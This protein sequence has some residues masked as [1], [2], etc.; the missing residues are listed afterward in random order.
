MPA[1]FLKHWA[2]AFVAIAAAVGTVGLVADPFGVYGTRLVPRLARCKPSLRDYARLAKAYGVAA[3]RPAT[4]L[5]GTSRVARGLDP[6]DP[7]LQRRLGRTYNLGLPGGT[8]D[9]MAALARH[10]AATSPELRTLV[11]GLEPGVFFHDPRPPHASWRTGSTPHP[12]F[13]L[14][15]ARDTLFS[16]DS[17]RATAALLNDDF[18]CE[19]PYLGDGFYQDNLD[20]KMAPRGVRWGAQRIVR[21]GCRHYLPLSRGTPPAAAQAAAQAE[22]FRELLRWSRERGLRVRLFITPLHVRYLEMLRAIGF[23]PIVEDWKR[24]TTRAVAEAAREGADVELW[25][26][27][28]YHPL[29]TEPIP[30]LGDRET[31]MRWYWEP[32]HFR[33]VLGRQIVARMIAG[34]DGTEA[35]A[36][37]GRRLTPENVEAHLAAAWEAGERHRAA[38][39]AQVDEA[40]AAA[41]R[42]AAE[43]AR[44]QPALTPTS[45]P[46]YFRN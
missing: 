44:A 3:H 36:D 4:V 38:N 37:F 40:D 45:A 26:F 42:A 21:N 6:S 30:S 18:G 10:A 9:E 2:I 13:R 43:L 24:F 23:W 12:L 34:D 29:T 20:Q 27:S 31:R 15:R 5:I 41:A 8:L 11:I 28:T 22:V 33:P 16:L 32:S 7:V 25:D 14:A 46:A 17:L 35:P 39:P 19:S 1:R